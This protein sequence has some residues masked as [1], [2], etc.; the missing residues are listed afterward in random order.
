MDVKTAFLNGDLDEE[1][2]MVQPEGYVTLGQ[3]NK[4]C[5]LKRSLYGLKQAPKQW[6][7]KFDH[8]LVSNGYIVNASNSCVYSKSFGSGY[9]I[10]YLYVDDMLI[11]GTTVNIVN[12]TKN[13]LSSKFEM[14]DIGEGDVILGDGFSLCQ[15][16]EC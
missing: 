5:K 11:L 16:Q 15:S 1:I 12:D 8:V 4:V 6:Y 3:E 10:I 14:K 13:F 2:Y 9:V 7:E